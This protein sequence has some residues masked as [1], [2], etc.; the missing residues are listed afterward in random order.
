MRGIVKSGRWT[1]A[2]AWVFWT[3]LLLAW[4]S[5]RGSPLPEGGVVAGSALE[6]ADPKS[7]GP[8][9]VERLKPKNSDGLSVVQ[10][11]LL[12]FLRPM[13]I[14]DT[15]TEEEK[16]GNDG[17]KFNRVGK[18]IVGGVEKVSEFVN[19]VTNIPV[20]SVK[21]LSRGATEVLNN[22]GGRLVGLQR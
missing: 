3:W 15:I 16:Y 9:I 22:I 12:N 11:A 2:A 20:E 17:D 13:P 1:A 5:A 18:S 8:G 19:K 7:E 4:T 14:V 10:S 6:A 21:K